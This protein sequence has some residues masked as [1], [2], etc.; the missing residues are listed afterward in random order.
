LV[1]I[2]D[3]TTGDT[4]RDKLRVDTRKWLMSKF[5]PKR[6]GDKVTQEHTGPDGTP[7]Q[8]NTVYELPK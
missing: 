6:F 3:S 2:S 8:F 5:D 7:I 1:E 4:Q